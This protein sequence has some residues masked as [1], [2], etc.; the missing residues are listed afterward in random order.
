MPRPDGEEPSG[1]GVVRALGAGSTEPPSDA[2]LARL[3]ARGDRRAVALLYDRYIPLVRRL[4]V[5]TFGPGEDAKDLTQEVFIAV[6]EGLETLRD[7]GSLRS[8]VYAVAVN[9]AR[10][11]LRRRRRRPRLLFGRARTV[12]PRSLPDDDETRRAVECLYELLA[13]LDEEGRLSFVLR[14]IEQLPVATIAGLFG[15]SL[16]TAK[17]R[18]DRTSRMVFARARAVPELASY[19]PDPNELPDPDEEQHHG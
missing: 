18:L 3:V 7:P 5:R 10:T 8:F 2:E 14:H 16:A 6:V 9:T 15:W 1:R 17:R 13:E 19:L 4:V 12:V 11:E